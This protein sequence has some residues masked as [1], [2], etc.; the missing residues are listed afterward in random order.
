LQKTGIETRDFSYAVPY[1]KLGSVKASD[2]SVTVTCKKNEPCISQSLSVKECTQT[3]LR[4]VGCNGS[5][6]IEKKQLASATFSIC[7][8]QRSDDAKFAISTLMG[9]N[10]EE[11]LTIL[12]PIY[13]VP[14]K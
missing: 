7:S 10:E 8:K 6:K 13:T 4:T 14:S 11:G 3:L 12:S 1:W 5:K 9:F 2:N